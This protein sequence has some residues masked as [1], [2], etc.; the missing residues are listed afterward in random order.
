MT[1]SITYID[2]LNAALELVT[3]EEVQ[4]KLIALKAQIA[5]RNS[6]ERKPT[7]AQ[8]LTEE[9]TE[10]VREV[11]SQASEPLTVSEIMARDE[12]LSVL[13]NQKVSAVVRAMGADVVKSV[14]KRVSKYSLA[15]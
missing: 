10:V 12:R 9:L 6:S 13:T 2:A 3:D 4:D 8:K 11:L 5:K 7:K 14:E 15:A 1:K